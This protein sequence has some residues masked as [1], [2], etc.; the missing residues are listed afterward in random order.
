LFLHKTETEL[1]KQIIG[2]AQRMGRK[3]K[4]NIWY[5]MHENESIIKSKKN[6]DSEF[7]ITIGHINDVNVNKIIYNDG[8][9]V[10]FN[11]MGFSNFS[12]L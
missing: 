5:I 10:K 11:D 4:L 1:E 2:R 3:N 12:E 7:D 8:F 9:D 6:K